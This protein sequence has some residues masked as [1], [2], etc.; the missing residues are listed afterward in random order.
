VLH[1]RH[2]L[3]YFKTAGWEDEWISAAEN[4][5]RAEFNRSYACDTSGESG[6]GDVDAASECGGEAT[7]VTGK[8][9]PRFLLWLF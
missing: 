7:Q 6:D 8:V 3:T 9:Y 5:V 1:P 4:I 2:K